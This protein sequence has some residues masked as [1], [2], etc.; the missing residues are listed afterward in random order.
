MNEVNKTMNG[1][2]RSMRRQELTAVASDQHA[3]LN[4]EIRSK[5]NGGV[6]VGGEKRPEAPQ[7]TET[8]KDT[9]TGATT[10]PEAPRAPTGNAGIASTQVIAKPLDMNAAIRGALYRKPRHIVNRYTNTG[11]EV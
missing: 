2:F 7:A 10:Q 5:A 9:A 11:K 4:A 6:T 3:P 8:G 1:I